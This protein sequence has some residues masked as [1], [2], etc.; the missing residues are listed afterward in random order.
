[1]RYR[2]IAAAFILLANFFIAS[3]VQAQSAAVKYT[4]EDAFVRATPM[5]IS[6][7]YVI[8]YNPTDQPDQ[9]VKVTA[10]WAGK[11]ELHT[12]REDKQGVLTMKEVPYFN[13]PAKAT[14]SLRPNGEHIMLYQLKRPLK[15]GEIVKLT[16]HF[17][18]AGTQ[19][20]PFTVQ[21]IRY[22]GKTNGY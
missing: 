7:G 4:V 18:K 2:V 14:L 22:T 19:T 11:I 13:V 5:K 12:I 6:A 3:P 15:E 17:K 20:V 16:L 9:L 10:P 8:L 1:M 21:S